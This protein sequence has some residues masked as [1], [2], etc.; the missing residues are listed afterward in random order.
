MLL[1]KVNFL[2]SP[3]TPK[4]RKGNLLSRLIYLLCALGL[5]R[6]S[7]CTTSRLFPD[8]K[9]SSSSSSVTI[10]SRNRSPPL[11]TPNDHSSSL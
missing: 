7:P 9:S 8:K 6:T 4:N 5:Q 2:V 10:V 1:T 11:P 3:A